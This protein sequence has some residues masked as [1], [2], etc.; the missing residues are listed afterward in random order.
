MAK[1]V[2]AADLKSVTYGFA[3]SSPAEGTTVN[4]QSEMTRYIFPDL[5]AAVVCEAND[6]SVGVMQSCYKAPF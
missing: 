4:S 6:E 3:G 2:Y 5:I 1:L